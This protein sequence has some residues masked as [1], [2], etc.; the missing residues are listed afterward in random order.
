M[1]HSLLLRGLHLSTNGETH[2]YRTNSPVLLPQ[3]IIDP[4]EAPIPILSPVWHGHLAPAPPQQVRGSLCSLPW[5]L[6]SIERPGK[7]LRVREEV[8][9]EDSEGSKKKFFREKP[10]P[11]KHGKCGR[12]GGS[13][14]RTS[15][16]MMRTQGSIE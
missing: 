16:H 1:P 12:N 14:S 5:L 15:S 4:V 8:M 9:M 10:V 7:M 11:W 3:M 2:S 6:A 13:W